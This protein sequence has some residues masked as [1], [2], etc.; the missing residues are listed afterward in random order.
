MF[1]VDQ[2]QYQGNAE[3]DDPIEVQAIEDYEQLQSEFS[4][5]NNR[6]KSEETV[7]K[8][9]LSLYD[10]MDSQWIVFV[11]IGF[12]ISTLLGTGTAICLIRVFGAGLLATGVALSVV[13]SALILMVCCWRELNRSEYKLRVFVMLIAIAAGLTVSMSDA[14]LDWARDNWRVLSTTSIVFTTSVVSV[15][16]LIIASKGIKGE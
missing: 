15:L 3:V 6:K 11:E 12:T 7:R 5:S 1:E 14:G 2:Y 16:G 9:K 13:A 10:R 4:Y 8:R